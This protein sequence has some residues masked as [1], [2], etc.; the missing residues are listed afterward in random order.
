MALSIRIKLFMVGVIVTCIGMTISAFLLF[1]AVSTNSDFERLSALTQLATKIS[2]AVHELQKERGMSFTYL[3]SKGE[4][5]ADKLGGQRGASDAQLKA[6]NDFFEANAK[7]FETQEALKKRIAGINGK[8]KELSIMRQKI[9]SLAVDAKDAAG[10]YTETINL[11]LDAVS[12]LASS[13]DNVQMSRSLNAYLMFLRYK[14]FGGLER[15]TLS[16]TFAENAFGEGIRDRFISI[17]AL[18]KM[19]LDLFLKNAPDSFVSV[20]R[21]REKKEAFERVSSMC[22]VALSKNSDFGIDPKDWF[23]ISTQRIDILKECED[24]YSKE[25]LEFSKKIRGD[26]VFAATSL[27]LLSLALS[28]ALAFFLR[29][30]SVDIIKEAEDIKKQVA[31]IAANHDL[32]APITYKGDNEITHIVDNV[33]ILLKSFRSLIISAQ[34]GADENASIVHKLNS[35]SQLIGKRSEEQSREIEKSAENG[36]ILRRSV[37]DSREQIMHSKD[38]ISA[39]NKKL[40]ESKE[41]ILEMIEKI[42]VAVADENELAA[43]LVVVSRE[44]DEVKSVLSVISDIAEQTN[45]LALNAAIEAARAGEHGRGFAVVADEVRKL[46]ERTQKSLVES[47]STINVITQSIG[48]L[49]DAM[50][51]NSEKINFLAEKSADTQSAI[52]EVSEYMSQ[53]S[54]ISDKSAA[55]VTQMADG[56]LQMIEQINKVNELSASNTKSVEEIAQAVEHLD[57]LSE[58]LKASIAQFRT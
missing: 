31:D 52:I 48:E 45:L 46:A 19:T 22:Q 35:A 17:A 24:V 51:K 43:R 44:A 29:F 32:G 40:T 39:A 15:A 26:A 4:V 21:E 49:S 27:T 37:D 10:Y 7:E 9:S 50:T 47:N 8:L 42:Q 13:S 53:A 3:R 38:Q 23:A 28:L 14:E 36:Q 41:V 16:A 18:Q 30:V 5:F 55:K 1:R 33:N 6:M 11:L 57:A 34:K 20:Y 54:M 56:L 2:P 58:E 25:I 12:D